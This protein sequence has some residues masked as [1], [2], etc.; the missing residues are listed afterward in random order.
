[1]SRAQR[2][3]EQ[4]LRGI[5]H[6]AQRRWPYLWAL[7]K[8]YA[9]CRVRERP[10]CHSELQ[11]R[12]LGIIASSSPETQYIMNRESTRRLIFRFRRNRRAR[13]QTCHQRLNGLRPGN[14]WRRRRCLG[15]RVYLQQSLAAESLKNGKLKSKIPAKST[16]LRI[17][18]N[19]PGSLF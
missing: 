11:K 16:R 5:N 15:D 2:N 6:R 19:M 4:R 18:N 1:M 7:H 14:G 9:R 8:N 17:F 13:R 10:Q 12:C 3:A